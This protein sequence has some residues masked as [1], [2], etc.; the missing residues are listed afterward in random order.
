MNKIMSGDKYFGE[1]LMI[2]VYGADKAALWDK[3]L[4]TKSLTE[5]C[6]LL[7]VLALSEPLVTFTPDG[8]LKVP[9]GVTGIIVLAES[10]I[11]IHTFP[12]R[13]FLSADIYSCRHNMDQEAVTTFF[14]NKFKSD[15]V[16]VTFVHRGTRYPSADFD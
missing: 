15:D 5:L 12:A 7:G 14:K 4:V 11:S 8:E 13:R 6:N 9:G 16:D 1:H 2:D 10:H 3:E